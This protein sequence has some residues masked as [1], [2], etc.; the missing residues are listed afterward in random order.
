MHGWTVRQGRAEVLTDFYGVDMFT[1]KRVGSIWN[2]RTKA[3]I[4]LCG[5]V[6]WMDGFSALVNRFPLIIFVY[7]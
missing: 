4:G 6:K 1:Y 7:L 2:E 3:R 5:Y